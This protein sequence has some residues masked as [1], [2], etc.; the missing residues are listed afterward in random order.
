MK[1]LIVSIRGPTNE[2]R[3]GGMQNYIKEV[4]SRWVA[5]GHEVEVLCLNEAQN[6]LLLPENEN[7][8][9]IKVRRIGRYGDARGIIQLILNAYWRQHW[10]D[11]LVENI[12]GSP[13]FSPIWVGDSARLIC[14]KHHINGLDFLKNSRYIQGI[15]GLLFEQIATPL[16][17]RNTTFVVNSEKTKNDL[18]RVMF[19]G[20]GG[21]KIVTPGVH[22]RK[23]SENKFN[24]PTILYLGSLHLVRKKVD[25]L[26]EAFAVLNKEIPNSRL[27]IAGD[28]PD[29]DYLESKAGELPIIF[30]GFVSEKE[31]HRLFEK[32]WLFA[33]PSVKEGFGISW[34]E[35]NAHGLPV[36]AYENN[37]N[38]LGERSS[39]EVEA[40]NISDLSNALYN[41]IANDPLRKSMET[42]ALKNAQNYSWSDASNKMYQ[43]ISG[44]MSQ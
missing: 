12:M 38:T 11:M 14:I 9:G 18:V 44:K 15:V 41:I 1:V 28:G 26:I 23:L 40:G 3:S 31:K 7:V 17:Y 36:V 13:L 27:I 29:R 4:F 22:I 34:I 21:I 43:I 2:N 16:C 35:A 25:D 33:S 32:A 6:D 24:L 42:N 5:E 30:K 10:A 19:A 20:H 8:N 37:L 39:I